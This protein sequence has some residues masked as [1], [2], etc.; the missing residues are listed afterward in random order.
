MKSLEQMVAHMGWA[1]RNVIEALRRADPLDPTLVEL[2]GHVLG[3][4]HIWHARL[5][6]IPATV[7][8]WPKISLDQCVEVASDNLRQWSA[9]VT[10]LG[11][12]EENR[13]VTYTNSTGDTFTSTV[14]EILVHVAMH[15][16]YHRGQI[17][18]ALRADGQVPSPT[19]YI[20]FTRGAPT[21]TQRSAAR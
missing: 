12:D 21:A 11:P 1:D 16:S 2:F 5:V 17:A 14:G 18:W 10:R 7:A 9:L 3:A 8:V 13:A 6:G 20:A 4:E 19:D 15:G